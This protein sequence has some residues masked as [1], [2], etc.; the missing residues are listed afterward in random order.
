[1]LDRV[2]MI[3]VGCFEKPF[4]VIR[5]LPCLALKIT[6]DSGHEL[7][8]GV[9]DVIVVITYVATGGDHDSPGPPL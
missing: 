4:E 9:A 5:G 6:L 1:V 2:R 3:W 7:L 8:V